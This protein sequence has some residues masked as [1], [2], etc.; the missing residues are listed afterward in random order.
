MFL[1]QSVK[2][3]TPSLTIND[4]V[5]PTVFLETF[6]IDVKIAGP[7]ATTTLEMVF[8]NKSAKVL[9]AELVLPLPENTFVSGYALDINGKMREAVPVEKT[10]GTETF[11]RIER[12]KVDPGLLEKVEGNNFRTRIYPVP[13]NGARTIKV[14][15]EQELFLTDKN[16]LRYHL[17]LSYKKP[18]DYFKIDIAVVKSSFQPVVEEQPGNI[19]FHEW[20]NFYTASLEKKHFIPE[21]SLTIAV[22]K[23]ID[24]PEVMIQKKGAGYYFLINT[25]PKN[26]A[27]KKKLPGEIALIWDVSLTG[28][29]RNISSELE[30]LDR[31]IRKK[32]SL[33]VKL[34]LLNNAF[35]KVADFK[36]QNGNWTAL[37][38][39]IENIT[40][41]GATNLKNIDLNT[42]S[43]DEYFLFSDG[44]STFGE[45]EFM[46][47]G[48]PVHTISSSPAA[49]HAALK[50]I[51]QKSGGQFINLDR[52]KATEVVHTLWEEP[53]QFIGIKK[54]G[55]IN[56]TYPSI[57]TPVITNYSLVGIAST[58]KESITLQFGF[59]NEIVMEK[60]IVL[61]LTKNKADSSINLQRFWAQKKIAELDMQ[62]EKNKDAI[63]SLGKRFSIVSRNTSL[64]VL[65]TVNDYVQYE[66]EP[67]VE[68]RG[69]YDRLIKQRNANAH[70]NRESL[71]IEAAASMDELLIWWDKN[72]TPQARKNK[73]DE[74]NIS[75]PALT[76]VQ[77]TPPGTVQPIPV[78]DTITG[79]I[80][81]QI[82]DEKGKPIPGATIEVKGRRYGTA[83]DMNGNFKIGV[84]SSSRTLVFS[85]V[86]MQT[87][88]INAGN[89]SVINT[90]LDSDHVSLQE[91]VVV[92]YGTAKKQFV[93]GS[94]T[95]VQAKTLEVNNQLMGKVSGIS[96]TPSDHKIM[97]RGF[98]S[99]SNYDADDEKPNPVITVKEW[100]SDRIYLKEI[101]KTKPSNYYKKYIELRKEYLQ[102]PSFYYDMATFF[103]RQKDSITGLKILSNI[104]ELQFQDHE[105]YKLLGFTLKQIGSHDE[106]VYVF[107][108]ILDWRPQEPQSYRDYGLALMDAGY[109]QQ[110]LDTLYAALTKTYNVDTKDMF[111]GIEEVIVTEMNYLVASQKNKLDLSRIDTTLVHAMPVDIRVVLNWNKKDT[112]IDLWVTDPE[113]EKSYYSHKETTAGGKFSEDQTEGYGPEQFLLKKAIKGK[114]KIEVDYYADTQFSLAGPTTLMVEIFTHYGN[115][116][117]QRQILTLQM[118]KEEDEEILVGEFDFQ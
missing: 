22:P 28:L 110:A 19:Q 30:L 40:Y 31:Y 108:K 50:L 51:A 47:N 68:L 86:G 9:E 35:K 71:L 7:V 106:A 64:I 32:K 24:I 46:L 72:Y 45:A 80:T 2:S 69:E 21:Q 85:A 77:A 105:L 70:N 57:T 62:Y 90:Q 74:K 83:S 23:A 38:R 88:E 112:D 49:D 53:F 44:F 84:T 67:P 37:K 56:E 36:I 101:A 100:T 109:Y 26:S 41:D 33:V 25:F 17:P 20:N 14:S 76:T 59:G 5:D 113:G 75:T 96:I 89:S 114:Y 11:E 87:K 118:E 27:R 79:F 103:F 29:N 117:Q 18:V 99:E 55:G 13:A 91:V 4:K 42:I 63:S 94:I 78:S 92:G 6:T 73:L 54:T 81:G 61:D 3:Q 102:T 34:A 93:T 104:A 48:K 15:Y 16:V 52:L 116:R 82:T 95:T 12:R 98:A 43:S 60:T 8:R 111:D 65:E 39:T 97:L 58:T 107:R 66:I 10:K 115:G 1:A